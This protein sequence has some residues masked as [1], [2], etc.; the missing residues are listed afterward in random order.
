MI[1]KILLTIAVIIGLTWTIKTADKRSIFIT[2]GLALGIIFVFLPLPYLKTTGLT[3]FLIFAL[4]AFIYGLNHKGKTFERFIICAISLPIFMYW[5]F[6]L[7]HFPGVRIIK[8]FMIIPIIC[9]I[10]ALTKKHK[11]KSELGFL[12]ILAMDS[13]TL[14][15]E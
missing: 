8:L 14:L 11:L 2:G 10:I 5:S 4:I 9:F 7:L 3:I 13:F 6:A 1:F 12:L 15:L